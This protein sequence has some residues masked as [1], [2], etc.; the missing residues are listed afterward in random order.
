MRKEGSC[1]RGLDLAEKHR[2]VVGVGEAVR[3]RLFNSVR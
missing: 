2:D 1:I 3:V